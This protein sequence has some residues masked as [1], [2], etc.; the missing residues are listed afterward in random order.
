VV[1]EQISD[2][3]NNAINSLFVRKTDCVDSTVEVRKEI[4]YIVSNIS[5][6]TTNKKTIHAM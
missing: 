1:L 6:L 3:K 4:Y 2:E 5:I